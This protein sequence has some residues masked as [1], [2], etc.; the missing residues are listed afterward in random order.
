[1]VGWCHQCRPGYGWERWYLL[2]QGSMEVSVHA[3]HV[4]SLEV[5]K[6]KQI[7]H[8]LC[9]LTISLSFTVP[10]WVTGAEFP[11]SPCGSKCLLLHTSHIYMTLHDC[12]LQ[13]LLLLSFLI[14]PLMGSFFF[15]Q[16]SNSAHY[17]NVASFSDFQPFGGWSRPAIK[18][19]AGRVSHHH[20]Y[21]SL[22]S[23]LQLQ[24]KR[25]MVGWLVFFLSLSLFFL[26][27][28]NRWCHCLRCWRGQELVSLNSGPV[29]H[30]CMREGSSCQVLPINIYSILHDGSSLH[31][32]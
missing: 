27:L 23:S 28:P 9:F 7:A 12:H 4:C 8:M 26:F 16:F 31:W 2:F 20:Q 3:R 6:K 5:E 24:W 32:F 22:K 11:A 10:S 14:T 13:L 15:P 1:M 19:Y 18:Q 21:P 17:D 25:R 30:L 29:W